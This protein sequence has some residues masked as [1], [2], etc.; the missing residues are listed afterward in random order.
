MSLER[1]SEHFT[2]GM[3][4]R[5]GYEIYAFKDKLVQKHVSDPTRLSLLTR[6]PLP[7]QTFSTDPSSVCGLAHSPPFQNHRTLP[8]ELT[9]WLTKR[10]PASPI[11]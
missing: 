10:A 2:Q 1:K 3:I 5:V 9:V 7:S 6:P 8:L 4:N 11:N